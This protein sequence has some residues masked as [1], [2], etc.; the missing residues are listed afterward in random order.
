MATSWLFVKYLT[1]TVDFQAEFSMASGY[2]PVIKSVAN[3]EVYAEFVAGA[4]GGD[5][6]AALAAKVCLER[7]DA[8][9]T[10]PAFPGSSEARSR[11]GELMAGCMTDA[12]GTG[13]PTKPENDAKLDKLIQKRFDEAITKCKQFHRGLWYLRRADEN[14]PQS[15][16]PAADPDAAALHG[17]RRGGGNHR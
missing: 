3:N 9:Y 10:S 1:T 4:D 7:V 17:V 14:T 16:F 6:V 11:V 15:I 5:N 2:V 8:Y 12:A 13:R